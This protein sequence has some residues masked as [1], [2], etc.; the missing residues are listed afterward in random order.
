MQPLLPHQ[1]VGGTKVAE[2]HVEPQLLC[3]DR[4]A[5]LS[6]KFR[7]KHS[8]TWSPSGILVP[9]QIEK[10]NKRTTRKKRLCLGID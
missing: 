10:E 4:Q 3:N 6:S 5:L 9:V 1:Y 8:P 7:S 2:Q